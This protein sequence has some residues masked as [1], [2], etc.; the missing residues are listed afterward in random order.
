VENIVATF[1][2]NFPGKS[3]VHVY[4]KTTDGNPNSAGGGDVE[5][6]TY[7]NNST[8][9]VLLKNVYDVVVKIGSETYILDDVDCTGNTC[10]YSLAVVKLID[11][12]GSGLAGGVARY[13]AG[14][15]KT[16]GTT[17]A[18]GVL[19]AAIQGAPGNYP[20]DMSYA[21]ATQQISQNIA[22]NPT[23]I[24]QT[25]LVTFQLRDSGDTTDLGG[26]AE[27][28]AGTWHTFGGGTTETTM[29]LLPLNYPFRVSYGGASLQISQDVGTNPLVKFQ[30]A[31]VTFQLRDSGDTTD[32]GG[33][34]EYYAGTWHTFGGGT[35]QTTMELLPLNYP[36]RVSYGGASL[37]MSQDIG[38]NPLVKF[39]TKLVTFQLRN[40][41][42]TADLGGGAEYYANGWYTFGG[43]TTQTTMELLP[44]NYPFRVSYGGASLQ[45]SQD[46]GTNPLVKFQ[47]KLVTFQ[48]R[49]SGD[50]ADLGGGAEYYANGWYT[51]GG[52]TTQTTME[53][54]PLN[55]PFRVSYGGASLQMSQDIDANPLVKFQTGQVHSDTATC[56]QYYANGWKAFTQ[57]M[58]LLPVS[59]PFQFNDGTPQTNYT[60]AVGTINHIH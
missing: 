39:Q 20:F 3:S 11:S 12:G 31:L 2:L 26:G 29:E 50:T 36:F 34:A 42:D 24:F 46:I 38:A 1:T 17:P 18:S 7:Q 59:Y 27:Y 25:A 56:T 16:I 55:Y 57:D 43:G 21:G 37:Q 41:G 22:T 14:T 53:L 47:T 19:V 28:Y 30:T 51:F 8:T 33:G 5:N 4:V 13:Y 48:L 52:G 45:M 9:M 10:I 35:T 44:L 15:W 6:R 32:L 23:V 54:L 49:N 60:I 58:D 40:S